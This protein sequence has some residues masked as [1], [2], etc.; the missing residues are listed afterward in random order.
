MALNFLST[1]DDTI[2]KEDVSDIVY[3]LSADE[4]YLQRNLAKGQ[5]AI[6]TFHQYMQDTAETVAD[7]AAIEGADPANS[8]ATQPTKIGNFTQIFEK[9]LTIS[10]TEMAVA[11]YGQSDPVT[12]QK[13]K[14]LKSISNDIEL[15]LMQGT[16]AS[17]TGTG[18]RRLRG[19]LASITT[20]ATVQ[21]SAQ[22][23]TETILGDA[24]QSVW[25]QGGNVDMVMA[26][27][28]LKRQMS[29][30]NAGGTVQRYQDAETG[31]ISN[32][33]EIYISDASSKPIMLM[34]HRYVPASASGA[35]VVGI[36]SDFF[37]ISELRPLTMTPLATS[38]DAQK[39][40]VVGEL[41][42]EDRNEKAGFEVSR[43]HNAT[44]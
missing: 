8:L 16:A 29:K 37:G 15:A 13:A 12:Y 20:N 9:G 4:T 31:K 19:L 2:R 27:M 1:Y 28:P 32:K 36:D 43:L 11:H 24:I 42:L 41:T 22:T 30:F 5:K 35:T 10:G 40:Q 33:I 6:N 34:P 3:Y 7:N 39:Y 17:G 26:G 25:A 38:G 18:A 44:F 23:L 21:A 14:K